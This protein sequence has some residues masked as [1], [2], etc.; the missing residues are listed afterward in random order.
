MSF[1]ITPEDFIRRQGWSCKQRSGVW[2]VKTC[3]FCNGGDHRRQGTFKIGCVSGKF[4]C[5]RVSCGANGSFWDLFISFGLNPKDFYERNQKPSSK[6]KQK[7][8][9][10][11]GSL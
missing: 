5:F 7:R 11:Y 2:V 9:F 3:P 4:E 6:Q 8:G 1:T 10:I